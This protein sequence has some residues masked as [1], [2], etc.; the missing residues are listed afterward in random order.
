MHVVMNDNSLSASKHL[1]GVFP[2]IERSFRQLESVPRPFSYCLSK[3][4]P[5][6]LFCKHLP[7]FIKTNMRKERRLGLYC[8]DSVDTASYI[9]VTNYD[10]AQNVP[11]LTTI[12]CL[13]NASISL[14]RML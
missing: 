6:V 12:Y 10:E 5:T 8:M 9:R 3:I 14:M 2:P 1:R 7:T 11:N 13:T 4:P